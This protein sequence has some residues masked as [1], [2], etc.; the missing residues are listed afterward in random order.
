MQN[1]NFFAHFFGKFIIYVSMYLI[2]IY[3]ILTGLNSAYFLRVYIKHEAYVI[4]CNLKK[5]KLAP[6]CRNPAR[7][8]TFVRQMAPQFKNNFFFS[9]K[10]S[11]SLS[12][13]LEYE[14]WLNIII[15]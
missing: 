5:T 1:F 13:L 9:N 3:V 14:D 8:S 10:I 15:N 4:F 2:V 7:S 12:I 11:S 6:D